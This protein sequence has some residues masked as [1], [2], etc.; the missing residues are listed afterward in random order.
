MGAGAFF[1]PAL[2][3]SPFTR[4][5]PVHFCIIDGLTYPFGVYSLCPF[6]LPS[7]LAFVALLWLMR[8]MEGSLAAFV[9]GTALM[10]WGSAQTARMDVSFT[11]L[12]VLAAWMV[13]RSFDGERTLVWA[14]VATGIAMLVKGPMAP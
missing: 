1:L 10:V 14:G 8:R 6:V 4:K 12:L 9:C 13:Q 3:G 7:L 5:P 2:E 11:A